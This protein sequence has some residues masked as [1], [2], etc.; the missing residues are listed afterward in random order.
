MSGQVLLVL[1]IHSPFF[2]GHSLQDYKICDSTTAYM[3]NNFIQKNRNNNLVLKY[4]SKDIVIKY[5]TIYVKIITDADIIDAYHKLCSNSLCR[6]SA[7][8]FDCIKKN[9]SMDNSHNSN[10]FNL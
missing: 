6:S 7:S 2:F 8:I 9:I 1:S 3:I 5:H 4:D 10:N